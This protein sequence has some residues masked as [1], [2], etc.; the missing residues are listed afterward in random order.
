MV[1]FPTPMVDFWTRWSVS[2]PDGRFPDPDGQFPDPDGR[3][4]DPDGRFPDPDGPFA[5]PNGRFPKKRRR[6]K[7][8]RTEIPVRTV[9]SRGPQLLR[10][11]FS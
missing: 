7:N 1:D 9:R 4:P 2:Q 5:D 8:V 6:H 10:G 3:F 11:L